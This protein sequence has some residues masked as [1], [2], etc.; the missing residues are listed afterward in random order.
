MRQQ[1]G[2]VT[3]GS[4]ARLLL[5]LCLPVRLHWPWSSRGS[6]LMAAVLVAA[7][8][9]LGCERG[10]LSRRLAREQG[11]TPPQ[12]TLT[13]TDCPPDLLRCVGRGI[14]RSLPAHIPE[15]CNGETCACPFAPIGRCDT[16]CLLE[17]EAVVLP[18]GVPPEQLCAPR[19]PADVLL[20]LGAEAKAVSL[21]VPCHEGE[22]VRCNRGELIDCAQQRVVGR[23]ALGCVVE[24]GLAVDDDAGVAALLV[25]CKRSAVSVPAP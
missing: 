10:C 3:T 20:P 5:P 6:L 11:D 1:R 19:V 15:G 4:R 2:R 17:G 8:E 25:L 12:I 13:G 18:P 14:E 22:S 7:P 21:A 9:T 23:C 16:R 24:D